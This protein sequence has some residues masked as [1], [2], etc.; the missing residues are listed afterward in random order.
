MKCSTVL[1]VC[2]QITISLTLLACD[3]SPKEESK[4]S[5]WD[6]LSLQALS[7]GDVPLILALIP[8]SP[9]N[10]DGLR[11]AT[12]FAIAEVFR[13]EGTESQYGLGAAFVSNASG[14]T[15]GFSESTETSGPS[16]VVYVLLDLEGAGDLSNAAY[17]YTV[18]NVGGGFDSTNNSDLPGVPVSDQGGSSGP[19]LSYGE[20]SGFA[21]NLY[22]GG[23]WEGRVATYNPGCSG[24][25]YVDEAPKFSVGLDEGNYDL[26]FIPVTSKDADGVV[27]ESFNGTA[28]VTS[29]EDGNMLARL[30]AVP[31][32][33]VSVDYTF[34]SKILTYFIS[35]HTNTYLVSEEE[36]TL[37][38]QGGSSEG[39]EWEHSN[40]CFGYWRA[41]KQ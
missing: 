6:G 23:Y 13:V 30:T 22:N 14:T 33:G 2:M 8:D 28:G 37:T 29:D 19:S 31:V 26:D 21:G 5:S 18:I 7:E 10:P 16:E 34:F 20:I 36:F 3:S 12:R 25:W 32:D 27:C 15:T 38:L 35:P 39:R 1:G 4:A 40:G 41:T 9:I 11:C 17:A 24:T